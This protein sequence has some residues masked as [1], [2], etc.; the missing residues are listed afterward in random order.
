VTA[1]QLCAFQMT[2]DKEVRSR[3]LLLFVQPS[4][5]LNDDVAPAQV[6]PSVASATCPTTTR[7]LRTNFH[8]KATARFSTENG[9]LSFGDVKLN[10]S[11]HPARALFA[12]V[13]ALRTARQEYA[14]K[15]D[16]TCL[17]EIVTASDQ[18]SAYEVTSEL[19]PE[20]RSP[21]IRCPT[22]ILPKVRRQTVS[23]SSSVV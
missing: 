14:P 11:Q 12:C 7:E 16:R 8:I 20:L 22:K 18:K 13:S 1:C 17:I 23:Y 6:C 9:C 4:T 10:K 5:R 15:Y 2:Y 21:S 3:R 19:P